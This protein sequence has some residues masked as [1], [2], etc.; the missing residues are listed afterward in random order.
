MDSLDECMKALDLLSTTDDPRPLGSLAIDIGNIFGE[1]GPEFRDV[2]LAWYER[3]VQRLHRPGDEDELSRAYLNLGVTVGESRPQ[4]GLDQ[5]E[6]AAEAAETAHD[7]RGAAR[8]LVAA[9][10]LR[11]ALGQIEDAERDNEQ[12]ARLLEHTADELGR[13]WV[14]V[15]RGSIAERRGLWEEAERAFETAVEICRRHELPADEAEAAFRLARLRYKT[16]DL[17]GARRAY[18][19][20][21]DLGL[22][23]LRPLLASQFVELGGQLGV[24]PPT[25]SAEGAPPRASTADPPDPRG[26]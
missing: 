3:A 12:V 5:L 14:E 7:A 21:S 11:L 17:D 18:T 8:A 9:A 25:A 23:E 26:L 22:P 24:T 2:A 1:V 20:A 6:K 4:D 13:G 15:N 19:V 16:R 10:E